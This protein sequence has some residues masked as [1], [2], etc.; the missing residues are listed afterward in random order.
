MLGFNLESLY[1]SLKNRDKNTV[2]LGYLALLETVYYF[3]ENVK[4]HF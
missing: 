3:M 1:V 4:S 2:I